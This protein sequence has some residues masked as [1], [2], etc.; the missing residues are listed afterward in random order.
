MLWWSPEE[1]IVWELEQLSAGGYE[2]Q[3]PLVTAPPLTLFVYASIG[4]E[5]HQL[6]VDFPELFPYFRFEVRAPTLSL[7]HHQ[8][9]FGKNLCL[10]PRGTEHWDISKSLAWYLDVQ[11]PKA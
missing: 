3:Q 11:L 4:G 8:H 5:R 9:P 10:M 2:F 6:E 7:S 1:R